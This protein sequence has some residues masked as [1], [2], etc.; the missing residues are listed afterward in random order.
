MGAI[1]FRKHHK[2]VHG[3]IWRLDINVFFDHVTQW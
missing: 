2:G 1:L 3:T